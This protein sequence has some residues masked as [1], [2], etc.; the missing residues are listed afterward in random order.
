[1]T[2][3]ALWNLL[4][5]LYIGSNI[6]FYRL[7]VEE[8]NIF[9]LIFVFVVFNAYRLCIAT[10]FYWFGIK[11][12]KFLSSS[13]SSLHHHIFVRIFSKNFIFFVSVKCQANVYGHSSWQ[14]S[15]HSVL[16]YW[17]AHKYKGFL[18]K[19]TLERGYMI[20]DRVDRIEKYGSSAWDCEKFCNRQ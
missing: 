6:C 16:F 1:V 5:S 13:F 4:E 3:S 9:F 2:L 8:K 18:N 12:I 17:F 15:L 7:T 14:Y 20:C 11:A 19:I 10:D